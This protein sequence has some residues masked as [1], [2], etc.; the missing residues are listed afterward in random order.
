MTVCP[1]CGNEYDRLAQHWAVGSCD[2]PSLPDE[3]VE[4]LTGV[5]MG[6]GT[7]H[8]PDSARN[9]RLQVTNISRPFLEWLD[10]RLNWF[11]TGVSL[12]RTSAEITAENAR[13]SHERF[14]SLTYDI[15]DQ[16]ELSTRRHPELNRF[17]SW[18]EDGYKR[19]PADIE[20]TPRVLKQWYVCDGSLLWGT[21]G[22]QRP[23][24]WLS[25]SDAEDRS[26]RL[27]MLFNGDPPSPSIRENRIM[28]GA[29]ETET[30]FEYVRPEQ[31]GYG[32][33]F[34]TESR[35][36]YRDAKEAFYETRT[37]TTDQ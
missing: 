12:K 9:A 31:P 30:F 23:N 34:V 15:R 20:L 13:S 4:V 22:H 33:K 27:S 14:S 8:W 26:T 16:Y 21:A 10:E 18:Y 35:A 29:D 37:T 6:D 11:S 36:T 2:Y 24:L 5:L 32:Y 28:F 3:W 17:A 1:T 7:V 19:F 25:C